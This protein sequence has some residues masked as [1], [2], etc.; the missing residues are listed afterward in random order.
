MAVN[1]LRQVLLVEDDEELLDLMAE[2]F[3]DAGYVVMKAN[4]AEAALE[5]LKIKNPQ[6]MFL[7]LKLPG[8]SGVDLC[9]QIRKSFPLANIFAVTG[10]HSFFELTSCREAGFDDY[11]MKPV[12][13]ELLIA[14]ADQAY[15]RI[16]RWRKGQSKK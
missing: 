16:S 6:I 15:E 10:H 1:P 14:T 11:F 8:K 12:E 7:D 3:E 13:M 9:I 5:N 4:S 2:S